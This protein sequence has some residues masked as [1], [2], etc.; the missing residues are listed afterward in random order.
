MVDRDAR[1]V[2]TTMTGDRAGESTLAN[3]SIRAMLGRFSP[4]GIRGRLTILMFHRVHE[5][6]DSLFPNQM[7]A[8]MF[9]E[10]MRW[11]RTW[12]NVLPL[13][14]ATTRWLAEALP[15]RALA[16]TFDDG[17]A[18][19]CTVALPILR[20]LDLHATFFVS[21]A[22]HRWRAAC[23]TTPSSKQS[24]ERLATYSTSRASVL[25]RIASATPEER[26]QAINAI[27]R[28]LKYLSS[29]HRQTQTVAIAAAGEGPS[30]AKD[31]M[32]TATQ[33]R[34]L[35]G[36][37]HG[38]R[39]PHDDAPDPCSARRRFGASGDW[40]RSRGAGGHGSS[41]DPTVRISER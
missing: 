41:A 39:R 27:L 36:R 8:A 9:R 12:F 38:Y 11:I 5:R 31:L 22:F 21:T 3:R 29:T 19:N 35:G 25:A 1:G 7:H 13:D 34:S 6:P 17:Y 28:Q 23:G 26:R 10:R 16:I 14:Q 4:A 20:Q 24:A 30:L 18:D 15:A 32:M 2:Q 40:R 37:R 33:L